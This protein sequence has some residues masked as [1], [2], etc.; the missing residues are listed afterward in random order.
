MF[1]YC[2]GTK[3][4][5]GESGIGLGW[6]REDVRPEDVTGDNRADHLVIQGDRVQAWENQGGD[7]LTP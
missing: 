1:P 4:P 6:T 5:G 2:H 7:N 3:K